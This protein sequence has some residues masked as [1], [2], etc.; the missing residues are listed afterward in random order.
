MPGSRVA[1]RR[2][3]AVN[4]FRW[5]LTWP[6][7]NDFRGTLHQTPFVR[8]PFF[9]NSGSTA[10]LMCEIS[11]VFI[12]TKG[13][14]IR[15]QVRLFTTKTGANGYG[16]RQPVTASVG[17]ASMLS[18]WPMSTGKRRKRSETRLKWKSPFAEDGTGALQ[19]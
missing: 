19:W 10:T 8:Q 7:S 12:A 6:V 1:L 15:P 5:G 4:Q 18:A 11:W 17:R 16:L 9:Y 3:Y 14:E 2:W 13:P